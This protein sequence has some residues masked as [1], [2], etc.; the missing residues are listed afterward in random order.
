[1]DSHIGPYGNPGSS[2][3]GDACEKGNVVLDLRLVVTRLL[4][5]RVSR[6]VRCGELSKFTGHARVV[7]NENKYC[8][9]ELRER[10]DTNSRSRRNW[11]RQ[12]E[13][14]KERTS[15]KGPMIEDRVRL[16]LRIW[17]AR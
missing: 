5:S 6:S 13:Y 1:M 9:V 16:Y 8:K 10:S 11:K 17:V 12:V 15:R 2:K 7:H 3:R 4:S 14:S